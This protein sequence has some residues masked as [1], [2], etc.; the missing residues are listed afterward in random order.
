[1]IVTCT[2]CQARFRIPDERIGPRGAKVRCSKCKNVFVARPAAAEAPP[3][4]RE[5]SA[6]PPVG[7]GP[8]VDPFGAGG[9]PGAD[10]FAAADPFAPSGGAAQADPFAVPARSGSSTSASHLPVTDLSDL[11]SPPAPAPGGLTALA[12]PLPATPEPPAGGGP[13]EAAV[14]S[15]DDLVLE[16]PSRAIPMGPPPLKPAARS[17]SPGFDFGASGDL[18]EPSPGEPAGPPPS[19]EFAAPGT[20]L[21][22]LP[23]VA[24]APDLDLGAVPG[25]ATFA[26]ADPFAA[27]GAASLAPDGLA[28]EA[29]MPRVPTITEP[30]PSEKPPAPARPVIAA[31]RKAGPAPVVG[32]LSGP[33]LGGRLRGFLAN[34]FSLAVLLAVAAGLLSWWLR[35]ADAGRA[36]SAKGPVAAVVAS[37]GLYET[38]A[39]PPV[40]FVRGEVVSRSAAPL[41]RVTVRAEVVQG[42][43]VTARA[44]GLAGAVPTAEEV[45][46]IAGPE[47]A[48]RLRARVASRAPGRLEPGESLPFLLVFDAAPPGFREALV[49][50]SAEPAGGDRLRAR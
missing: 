14:T 44:E 38:S 23:G 1:M 29:G 50:V 32:P 13:A 7:S 24:A 27:G 26:G 33:A 45:A 39:G 5:G 25:A 4:A 40:L 8:Q 49:R 3:A 35:A 28:P 34:A 6:R 36:A 19:F 43:E 9:P 42:G 10:P 11:T 12:A 47:G 17:P 46:Q 31:R 21:G 18:A 20:D 16:E 2:S 37:S 41:G 48:A 30:L 15:A 22:E